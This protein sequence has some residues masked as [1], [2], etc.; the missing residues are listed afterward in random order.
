MD[1]V[2]I[3][4]EQRAANR[5]ERLLKDI[6]ASH[7][8]LAKLE[9]VEESIVWL[10]SNLPDLIISDIQLADGMSFEIYEKIKPHCPIIFT[11]AYD[12]FAIEAFETNGIDYLLK[13]VE[14]ERL[15]KALNKLAAFQPKVDLDQLIK[16]SQQARKDYKTRFMVKVGDKIKSI[17]VEDIAAFYSMDKGTFLHTRSN[18]NYVL[19]FTMDSVEE[20]MDPNI[21]FRISR[22]YLLRIDA[23]SE[24]IAHSNSR[25]KIK[26]NGFDEG[27]MIVARERVKNFKQWLDQ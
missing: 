12:H 11:T 18:R 17:P 22:K 3:E 16:L 7:R 24:V 13:P 20:M 15:E 6:D 27:D 2:I 10:E 5:I 14:Q 26:I 23:I 8:I 21:F 25:L 19:D 1:I 9:S 4:D